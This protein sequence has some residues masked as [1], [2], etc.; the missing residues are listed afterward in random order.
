VAKTL[1]DLH[2]RVAH[3]ATR[4]GGV[5]PIHKGGRLD[6]GRSLN[7]ETRMTT[8]IKNSETQM[9][10]QKGPELDEEVIELGQASQ[11]TRGF[12]G[13]Y[14]EPSMLPLRLSN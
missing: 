10:E 5:R 2:L 4:N 1:I 7:R 13:I 11:K 14:F 8:E 3:G 6:V 12:I 9:I